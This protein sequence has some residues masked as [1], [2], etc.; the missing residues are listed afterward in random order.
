MHPPDWDDDSTLCRECGADL[1]VIG[2]PGPSHRPG[3]SFD[4][5]PSTRRTEDEV[6]EDEVL[7]FL[8]ESLR[9]RR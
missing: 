5:S 1:E 2:P 3:C 7:R 8:Q 6:S 4:Y 9:R